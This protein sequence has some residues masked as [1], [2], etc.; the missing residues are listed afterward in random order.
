M[1]WIFVVYGTLLVIGFILN[2]LARHAST[3]GPLIR[4]AMSFCFASVAAWSV[5]TLL[6]FWTDGWKLHVPAGNLMWPTITW[7]IVT[8]ICAQTAILSKGS[9]Y[10]FGLPFFLFALVMAISP[11]LPTFPAD[12]S[13]A[14]F[15]SVAFILSLTGAIP[16]SHWARGTAVVCLQIYLFTVM[17]AVP[18]FNWRVAKEDGFVQWL[19]L[20]ECTA[21]SKAMIWP[22]FAFER[23][24]P[25]TKQPENLATVANS[26]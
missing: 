26:Q 14:C 21:T 4:N 2:A 17:C 24:A 25:Q 13:V 11:F 22:Y 8:F 12:G 3:K 18:Y 9:P 7:L 20:G 10:A 19:L 5:T 1:I 23:S 6:G 16:I 15:L